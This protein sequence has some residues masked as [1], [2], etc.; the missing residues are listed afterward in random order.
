MSVELHDSCDSLY[1]SLVT[2]Y[3]HEAEEV[4][5]QATHH[6]LLLP[7][8]LWGGELG[9]T[10]VARHLGHNS[11]DSLYGSLV[12]AYLKCLDMT[13]S[14]DQEAPETTRLDCVLM[15]ATMIF[16]ILRFVFT[17]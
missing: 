11:C 6:R 12:T 14:R 15:A 2:A 8:R 16:I 3:L 1:D 13:Y 7:Q 4:D 10:E 9:G 17:L 5:Q